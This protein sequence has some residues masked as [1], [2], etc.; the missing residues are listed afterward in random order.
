MK[1]K[2]KRVLSSNVPLWFHR[3][4]AV[5]AAKKDITMSEYVYKLLRLAL[6]RED[7]LDREVARR[8]APQLEFPPILVET[9]DE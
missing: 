3:E 6:R 7:W 8:S 5:R 2:E 1:H 4:L 9:L